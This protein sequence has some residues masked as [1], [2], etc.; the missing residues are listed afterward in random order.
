MAVAEQTKRFLKLQNRLYERAHRDAI[1]LK[2]LGYALRAQGVDAEKLYCDPELIPLPW[3]DCEHL[4]ALTHRQRCI[5][6]AM[7]YAELYAH[8][9]GAETLAIEFNT[10]IGSAVFPMY[11]DEYMV[12]FQESDEEH[13]HII[14]FH[15]MCRGLLGEKSAMR[16]E[17]PIAAAMVDRYR[18]RLSAE[19][20]GAMALLYRFLLN[21]VLKQT[22]SFMHPEADRETYDPLA[23]EI[24]HCHAADEARHFATSIE[25]G[26]KLLHS[27][28]AQSRNEVRELLAFLTSHLIRDRF[29]TDQL[30]A[31]TVEHDRA[32]RALRHA[33]SHAEF[34]GVPVPV[35]EIVQS[36]GRRGLVVA[37]TSAL[38]RTRQWL[39]SQIVQ[40]IERAELPVK[41]QGD[42]YD[43]FCFHQQV[44]DGA[45]SPAQDR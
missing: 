8:T 22:E 26:I 41:M 39:A 35:D 17:Y 9:V 10:K 19:G 14:C 21:L 7:Y 29:I 34:G 31:P 32:V 23:V 24:S 38:G 42:S 44:K 45:A 36:W 1:E 11:S 33:V 43:R 37:E 15:A 25:L 40:L 18:P 6:T 28:D 5:V 16:V 4:Q 3:N 27:A 12:L 20:F 30:H 2:P 13:D